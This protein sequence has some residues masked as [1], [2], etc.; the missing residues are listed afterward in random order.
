M[1]LRLGMLALGVL[2]ASLG[3]C[4]EFEKQT[5]LVKLDPEAD[6]FRMRL[7]YEGIYGGGDDLEKDLALL[8]KVGERGTV[9]YLLDN[10]PM[11]IDVG[12][13]EEGE[14]DTPVAAILRPYTT[15][16]NGTFFRN[17][18][19]KL[20]AWQDVEVRKASVILLALNRLVSGAVLLGKA[21]PLKNADAETRELCKALA[22]SGHAWFRIDREGLHLT[23][24]ASADDVAKLKRGLL[25]LA[26]KQAVE[27]AADEM[28]EEA[29]AKEDEG[30][31][32]E[33]SGAKVEGKGD[34]S[35]SD[36]ERLYRVFSRNPFSWVQRGDTVTV[37]LPA[38]DRG[39]VVG[40]T[41]NVT[42]YVP[43]LLEPAKGQEK[44]PEL[45]AKVDPEM[46]VEKLVEG[47]GK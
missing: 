16:T 14:S 39:V 11:E 5:I 43:N 37:S 1:R 44:P 18:E 25:E 47:F 38:D 40:R 2:V 24:Q 31:K 30:A 8:R 4:I 19:G 27:A 17:A 7:V 28:K 26:A 29:T 12:K 13:P 23:F 20:C 21:D 3:G 34:G 9:F 42:R 10:W 22:L 33:P 15:V 6:V 35:I 32:T 41:W 36:Q 46:T 45:P